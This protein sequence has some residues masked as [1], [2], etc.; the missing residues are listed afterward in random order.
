MSDMVANDA[1]ARYLN[2]HLAGSVVALGLLEHLAADRAGTP[3]EAVLAGVRADIEADRA[4]LLEL[5]SGLD[6][7]PSQPRQATGWLVE[8]VGELKLRLDDSDDGALRRLEGLETVAL[9][10]EGKRAL[11]HA[12]AAA[13]ETAPE[14]PRLDYP[15]LVH[16]ADAQRQIVEGLR[17]QAAREAFGGGA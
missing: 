6:V 7:A 9:G 16:R 8:K 11:W 13:A 1:L 2:D 12:L 17:L 3:D 15:E 5:M 10:I 14:L 4:V